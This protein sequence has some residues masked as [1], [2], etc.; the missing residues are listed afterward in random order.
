M[1]LVICYMVE[2]VSTEGFLGGQPRIA[3]RRISVVQIVEWIQEEGMEPET[4]AA[5]FDLELA[6]I[7]RALTYQ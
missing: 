2:I 4:V 5:E 3:E 6:S 1:T 7:Y